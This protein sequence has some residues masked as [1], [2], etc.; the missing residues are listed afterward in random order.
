MKK[1]TNKIVDIFKYIDDKTLV[2]FD[3]DN[4]LIETI[5]EFG[6]YAW[7][8]CMTSRFQAKGYGIQDAMKRSCAAFAQ[9]EEFVEFKTVESETLDVINKLQNK[10]IKTMALTKRL[11]SMKQSTSKQLSSVNITF[12][13]NAIHDKEI[14]FDSM[15]GF[16][17]GILYSGLNDSKGEWLITFLEKIDYLPAN[18]L[19]VD[20][21]KHHI[22][23]MHKTL[24]VKG[25]PTTC[26]HYGATDLRMSQFNPA[27]ADKDLLE[28]IGR[29]HFDSVL[30]ELI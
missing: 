10:N 24:N 29:A 3:I 26:I 11:F 5:Q 17:D 27:R 2:I 28:A 1:Q 13:Q 8:C 19:F 23:E 6:S 4:T 9:I 18:V 12:L 16:A 21:A 7:S 15:A 25:I 14:E 20:D 22:D 30:K